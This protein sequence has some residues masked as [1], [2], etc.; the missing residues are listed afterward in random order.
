MIQKYLGEIIVDPEMEREL[1]EFYKSDY[2]YFKISKKYLYSI[3][4]NT[5]TEK[6]KELQAM[7]MAPVVR[8]EW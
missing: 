7:L 5:Y 8:R 3:A 1:E 6:R 4:G 2:E